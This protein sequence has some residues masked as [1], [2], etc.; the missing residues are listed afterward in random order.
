MVSEII[1][2]VVGLFVMLFSI[3]MVMWFGS[4]IGGAFDDER[5]T[6][7]TGLGGQA[8]GAIIGLIAG[9]ALFVDWFKS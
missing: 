8:W 3:G 4:A 7:S 6:Y 1:Q 9:I 2:V 5:S